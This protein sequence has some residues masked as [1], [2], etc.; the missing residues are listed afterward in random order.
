MASSDKKKGKGWIKLSRQILENPIWLERPYDRAHAWIDLILMVNHEDKEM[1]VNGQLIR[2]QRGQTLTSIPKLAARWG[3]SVGKV[4]RYL[5]VLRETNMIRITTR[6]KNGTAN[7]TVISLVKYE[8]FQTGRHADD[9]A[10]STADGTTDGTT[11]G[12]Q[13]RIY[14]NDKELKKR[15]RV[16]RFNENFESRTYDYDALEAAMLMAQE[17]G[18]G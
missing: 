6:N 13:T 8:F 16:N 3:W 2:I 17:K 14:K 10:D 12:T 9:T 11:D 15:A 1:M 18:T 7:G 4:R 5:Y